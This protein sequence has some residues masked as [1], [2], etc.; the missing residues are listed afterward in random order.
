MIAALYFVLTAIAAPISFG[1]VQFRISEA[2]VILPGFFFAAVP[3]VSV[4][5]FLANLLLGAALPDVIFGTL[6]TVIGAFGSYAL[7]KSPKLV[8]IPPIVS[9]MIIIP[10]VLR[11]AY[12]AEDMLWFMAVTVGIGEVLAVAVLGNLLAAALGKYAPQLLKE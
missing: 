1:P 5:C 6:A 2:L 8:C 11:Y 3:G 10:I 12:G 9:N 4:G 7:R